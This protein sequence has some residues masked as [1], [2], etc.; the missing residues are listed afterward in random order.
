MVDYKVLI[1][2]FTEEDYE[3]NNVNLHIHTNYSDGEA[4]FED[5]IEQA[6]RKNYRYISI[7]DHNTMQGYID[8]GVVDDMLIPAVEFDVW[9]KYVFCHLLAYGVDFNN[10]KLQKFFAKSNL[11]TK[12]DVY[13]LLPLRNFKN[14]V[15][16][17]HEAGGIA[18]LAHPAC[19]WAL[20]LDNLFKDMKKIGVDGIE[21]F[22]PYDRMR[23]IIKFHKREYV[24]RYAEKYGFIKTGGTDLHA[25]ILA[26][27]MIKKKLIKK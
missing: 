11:E 5:I 18:V 22:Y 7:S 2:S 20:S 19:Y 9:Y 1:S 6:K 14:L 24:I 25:K 16:A 4:D 8:T 21:C 27:L 12:V 13:R 23:G 3:S 17:I 15:D 26:P 10:E